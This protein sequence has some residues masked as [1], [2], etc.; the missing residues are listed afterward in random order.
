[1][2]DLL[3][4]YKNNESFDPLKV[5]FHF[6]CYFCSLKRKMDYTFCIVYA[7]S[8]LLSGIYTS[9]VSIGNLSNICHFLYLICSIPCNSA[10]IH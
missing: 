9:R 6:T 4:S 1:M 5:K 3:H 2:L 10:L 7:N 8:D